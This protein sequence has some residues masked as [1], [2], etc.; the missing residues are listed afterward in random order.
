MADTGA[1]GRI[2]KSGQTT[3]TVP[4]TGTSAAAIAL[5]DLTTSLD[6][7]TPTS[8]GAASTVTFRFNVNDPG[9]VMQ[10]GYSRM[11]AGTTPFNVVNGGSYLASA[12]LTRLGWG[13][14]TQACLPPC[15]QPAHF[16]IM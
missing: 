3:A 8:A 6:T 1:Y 4:L 15:P 2:L 13:A 7:S 12:T 11:Y 9:D 5:A 16:I 10:N 14:I